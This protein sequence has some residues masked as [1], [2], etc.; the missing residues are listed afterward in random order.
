MSKDNEKL[1][2]LLHDGTKRKFHDPL[3]RV[4]SRKITA[5]SKRSSKQHALKNAVIITSCCLILFVSTSICGKYTIK[6]QRTLCI[7]FL[8]HSC[9]IRIQD[10]KQKITGKKIY[11][12]KIRVEH[13]T[14]SA[15]CMRICRTLLNESLNLCCSA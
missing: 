10:I 12:L 15:K 4:N 7:L 2:V 8:N 6:K 1:P 11:P 13:T 5:E 14:G 3:I 9:C